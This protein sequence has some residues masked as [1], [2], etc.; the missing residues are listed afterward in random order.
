[1]PFIRLSILPFLLVL[2]YSP[3]AAFLHGG[4]RFAVRLAALDRLTLVV[5]LLAFC[6]RDRDLHTAVLEIHPRRD[7]RH[8]SLGR[9]A[10]QLPDLLPVQEQRAAPRRLVIARAAVAV[11]G[12]VD[13]VGPVLPAFHPREAV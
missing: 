5:R 6:Q 1:F 8:A 3:G 7:D 11:G 2:T 13:V 4:A 12:N 10:N 9:L